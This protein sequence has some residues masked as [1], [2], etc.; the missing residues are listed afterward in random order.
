VTDQLLDTSS[1]SLTS[2]QLA[3]GWAFVLQNDR[4]IRRLCA[5]MAQGCGLDVDDLVQEAALGIAR[6]HSGYD[7]GRAAP[8]TWIWWRVRR[9]R[10]MLTERCARLSREV[11]EEQGTLENLGGSCDPTD[12]SDRIV[13]VHQIL[14]LAD[15]DE[16][17]ACRT[18]L[19]ECDGAEAA[20]RLGIT[21]AGRDQRVKRLARRLAS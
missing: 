9:A 6:A 19:D 4:T 3:A 18:I 10:Q 20:R 15:A 17:A 12:A 7:A 8:V 16:R 11:C 1:R 21:A 2:A 13:L 5:S 14:A